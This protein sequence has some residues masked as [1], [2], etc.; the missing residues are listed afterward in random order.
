[1]SERAVDRIPRLAK[2]CRVGADGGILM[3]ESLLKLSPTG[4]KIV[5]L[6]DGV[7][8]LG[9]IVAALSKD[10]APEL[11]ERIEAETISFVMSLLER[12]AL[13]LQ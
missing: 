12:R 4:L 3:P 9:E 2:G 13:D 5:S 10:M 1:V 11:H 8:T 7:R 6:C